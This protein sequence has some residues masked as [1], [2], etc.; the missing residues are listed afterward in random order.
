M[1]KDFAFGKFP[2]THRQDHHR[3]GAGVLCL[4]RKPRR[5]RG[6]QIGNADH[7]GHPAVDRRDRDVDEYRRIS[8]PL[9]SG[10]HTGVY[11]FAG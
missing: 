3:I 10:R 1:L 2:V 4:L 5:L 8:V 7:E 9:R 6:R 11:V